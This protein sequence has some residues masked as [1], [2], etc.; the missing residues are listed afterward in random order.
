[1]FVE[2]TNFLFKGA[3]ELK[4]GTDYL[5]QVYIPNQASHHGYISH[6]LAR[7]ADDELFLMLRF[8]VRENSLGKGP[9]REGYKAFREL[10]ARPPAIV[11]GPNRADGEF[12]GD[13]PER[14]RE[15]SA[16]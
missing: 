13:E 2:I 12:Q 1:M 3:K 5:E 8:Q 10:C 14:G 9:D 4:A 7:G 16:T 15:A 11:C 6:V